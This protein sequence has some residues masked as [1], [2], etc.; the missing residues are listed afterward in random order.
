NTRPVNYLGFPA[1]NIPIGFDAN[2][3][4]TSVQLIGAPFTEH[5]LLRIARTLEREINFW[6]TRPKLS[7]A[8]D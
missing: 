8:N 4:P 1:V 6:A 3:L 7:P 5:K 2:G